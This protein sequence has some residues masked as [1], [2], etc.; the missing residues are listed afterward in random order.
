MRTLLLL[1]NCLLC[2]QVKAQPGKD[3][4]NKGIAINAEVKEALKQ[5]KLAKCCTLALSQ[6]TTDLS[7]FST[8]E[9]NKAI[10]AKMVTVNKKF[11]ALTVK[12]NYT[13]S[14]S[15]KTVLKKITGDVTD[16][17]AA[18]EAYIGPPEEKPDTI[19][20]RFKINDAASGKALPAT[21]GL[22]KPVTA[23]RPIKLVQDTGGYFTV[24][25]LPVAK[26][27][28][29]LIKPKPDTSLAGVNISLSVHTAPKVKEEGFVHTY[30]FTAALLILAGLLLT[31]LGYFFIKVK[32]DPLQQKKSVATGMVQ[33]KPVET[34][35]QEPIVP[36]AQPA[37]QGMDAYFDFEILMTAGPRKK[38]MSEPDADVDLGE[39]VC[40]GIL[41]NGKVLF[42]LLDGTSDL[43][44]MRNPVTKREYFSS[45]LLAQAIALRLKSTF[46]KSKDTTIDQLLLEILADVRL[47]WLA[48][49]NALP[50]EEKSK[51]REEIKEYK[52]LECATTAIISELHI[53]GELLAYRS[54][55]SK[56]F[57][58]KIE[59]GQLILLQSTLSGKN[60]E[61]NDRIFFR[62]M[63]KDESF[64][65]LFNKPLFEIV[66]EKNISAIIACSDGIGQQT[67]QLLKKHYGK[68]PDAVREEIAYQLQGTADDKSI[69]IIQIKEVQDHTKPI[70]LT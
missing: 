65:I 49:I 51:L 58:Y 8:T 28:D 14:C 12:S 30:P 20:L 35:K 5:K 26:N 60:D 4:L 24:Y 63:Y 44:F 40:G 41:E 36:V 3:I 54:G 66:T 42:W 67:E 59:N 48:N 15:I 62:L 27:S 6:Y 38:I 25:L 47:N 9:I 57:L 45:R 31:Y 16:W 11:I 18:I 7:T 10:A 43:S 53:N 69:G 64:D 46:Q 29:P 21:L 52:F 23:N 19:L 56:M 17:T 13:D 34:Q 32:T 2:L 50:D 1:L 61:S 70:N 55:D 39:D 33:P 22:E 68:S 37:I